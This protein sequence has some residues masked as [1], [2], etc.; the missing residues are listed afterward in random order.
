MRIET[1]CTE[2]TK[3]LS[4]EVCN[5]CEAS[6]LSRQFSNLDTNGLL[7]PQDDSPFVQ[8]LLDHLYPEET[9]A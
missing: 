3:A 5:A 7:I 6:L 2:C 1:N 4:I 8:G 9:E